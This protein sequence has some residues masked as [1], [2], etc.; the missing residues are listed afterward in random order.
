MLYLAHNGAWPTVDGGRRRDA[1]L[2]PRLWDKAD[3]EYVAIS[4]A[5]ER[6]TRGLTERAPGVSNWHVFPDESSRQTIPDR[7][8]VKARVLLE[9]TWAEFDII[10]VEGHYLLDLL[11]RCAWY[12][13]VLVEHNVESELLL[14]R[15]HLG[16]KIRRSE[17]DRVRRR[18]QQ[19]WQDVGRLVVL[20]ADDAALVARR[21]ARRPVVITNGWDHLDGECEVTGERCD[22]RPQVTFVGNYEY[23]PNRDAINWL[24]DEIFPMVRARVP[25]VQLRLVG[26]AVPQILGGDRV[27]AV[28]WAD[29]LPR[30]YRRADVVVV[31][32]RIGGG[33]K[34]KVT[35]A[36]Q[37]GC[38][39]VTTAVG[40][41]GIPSPFREQ[42][43]I[44][45]SAEELADLI[46]N[47]VARRN[48]PRPVEVP[49]GSPTWDGAAA[50][51]LTYWESVGDRTAPAAE[52]SR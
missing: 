8:S 7:S 44:G 43:A 15:A 52:E 27:E 45:A 48:Q 33:V 6:D 35:E 21:T 29:D 19:A 24:L 13:V 17:I 30:E 5:C 9:R 25:A 12:R 40:A 32:L 1:E 20:T 34:V 49:P 39:V 26:N 18:E 3:I 16:E 41:Q 2:M 23:A 42:L 10:H 31:P 46:A 14:Q 51:L 22:A 4:Q 47:A 50:K 37:Q 28:G 38:Q 11:P 36:L